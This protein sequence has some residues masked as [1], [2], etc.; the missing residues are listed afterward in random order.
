MK[1]D[2]RDK[3]FRVLNYWLGGQMTMK[4]PECDHIKDRIVKVRPIYG[5][6]YSGKRVKNSYCPKCGV[7]LDD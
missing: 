7:K 2:E 1:N 5:T 3:E 6:A 4:K